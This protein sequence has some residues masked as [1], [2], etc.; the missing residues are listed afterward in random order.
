[1]IDAQDM[2]A[3]ANMQKL[4]PIAAP[5]RGNVTSAAG[6]PITAVQAQYQPDKY[7]G[8]FVST[9]NAAARRAIRQMLGTFVRDGVPTVNP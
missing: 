2:E 3:I 4:P 9:E 8:H 1:V 7:D 5:A 6:A